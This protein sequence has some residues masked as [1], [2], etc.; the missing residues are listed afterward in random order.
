MIY[1]WRYPFLYKKMHSALD[2]L[3]ISRETHF[4]SWKLEAKLSL[5]L[6]FDCFYVV[7]QNDTLVYIYTYI[8]ICIYTY[9]YI[10]AYIY[11]YMHIYIYI[12]IYIYIY[13]YICIYIFIYILYIFTTIYNFE[14][15]R[16]EPKLFVWWRYFF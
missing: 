12:C 4:T 7:L 5:I 15:S 16:I 2:L 10:Y 13:I 9:I 11:I 1:F 14:Y 3:Q 6:L 8:Y